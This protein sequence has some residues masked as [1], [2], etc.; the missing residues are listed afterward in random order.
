ML[1]LLAM[2]VHAIGIYQFIVPSS[3][4]PPFC[5]SILFRYCLLDTSGG[6][7]WWRLVLDGTR[8]ATASLDGLDDGHGGSV[9]VWDGAEDDVA[10]VQPR[11]NDGGDEELGTVAVQI[12]RQVLKEFRMSK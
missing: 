8:L 3:S 10:T 4:S 9:T 11:G 7:H 2:P 5:L 6:D 1:L 12:V